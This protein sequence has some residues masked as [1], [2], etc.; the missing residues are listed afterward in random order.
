MAGWRLACM[1]SG[2]RDPC[3]ISWAAASRQLFCT[4]LGNRLVGKMSWSWNQNVTRLFDEPLLSWIQL[5]LLVDRRVD[6][7]DHCLNTE[8]TEVGEWWWLPSIYNWRRNSASRCSDYVDLGLEVIIKRLRRERCGVRRDWFQQRVQLPPNCF[9]V[10]TLANRCTLVCSVQMLKGP[11]L[12]FK[13]RLPAIRVLEQT[14]RVGVSRSAR[15]CV[16]RWSRKD[17]TTYRFEWCVLVE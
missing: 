2:R 8:R 16:P 15:V 10:L 17:P 11:A 7:F 13:L 1:I 9:H 4:C 5:T 3:S 14:T 6:G 12:Q